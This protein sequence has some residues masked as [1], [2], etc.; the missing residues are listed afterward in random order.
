MDICYNRKMNVNLKLLPLIYC[1][2]RLGLSD[3][4]PADVSEANEFYSFSKSS[5]EASLL[6]V[7]SLISDDTVADRDW[8]LF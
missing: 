2:A 4:V 6:C 3:G 8:R 5:D 1:V 7:Q